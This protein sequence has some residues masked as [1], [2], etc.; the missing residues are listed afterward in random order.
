MA[1]RCID[2]RWGVTATQAEMSA[3][4]LR[5]LREL[6]ASHLV[7]GMLGERYG[8]FVTARRES[9]PLPRSRVPTRARW[10]STRELPT[11]GS[12]RCPAALPPSHTLLSGHAPARRSSS[13]VPLRIISRGGSL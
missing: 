2:L 13:V 8:A 5:C 10:S 4:L 6:E 9:N 12:P 11:A 3:A 1:L 7:I